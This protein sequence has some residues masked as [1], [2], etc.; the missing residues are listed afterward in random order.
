MKV[1]VE[2]SGRHVHLS[3]E[4]LH[5]LFGENY[6]LKKKRDIS[7]PGQYLAHE[8]VILANGLDIIKDVKILGP[9]RN[10]TQIEILEDD[11]KLLK[12]NAPIRKSGDIEDSPGITIIG[13]FGEISVKEGVIRAERHIHLSSDDAEKLGLR[14]GGYSNVKIKDDILNFNVRAG[15]EHSSAIHLDK[16]DAFRLGIH[17]PVDRDLFGEIVKE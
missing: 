8:R 7:Q 13:P 12:I 3:K 10:E 9:V 15:N 4:H 2:V 17:N 1:K 11:A 5:K 16:D 6:E 14:N